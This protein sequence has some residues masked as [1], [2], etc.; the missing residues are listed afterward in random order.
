[1]PDIPTIYRPATQEEFDNFIRFADS[2]GGEWREAYASS[3][4]KVQV[5]DAKSRDSSINIVKLVAVLSNT[6]PLVMYDVLH[7][8]DYRKEWDDN[9]VEGYL[10]EQLDANNDVGYYSAKAP[11]ALVSARDFV[12]E[13]SWRVKED[14]EY[15]IMNHSVVH[16]K[17][18]EQKGFVRANSIMT[19]YLVRRNTTGTGCTLTYITQTDPRGWIPSSL[20]NQLTKTYAP[21]I[22][23]RLDA[24]AAKYRAWKDAHRPDYAPWRGLGSYP[25]KS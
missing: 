6:D 2:T 24:A 22:V 17:L 8:P 18:P 10:I 1:M 9:M 13:R 7:D 23:G 5:W 20:M 21:K 4:G 19:G 11:V 14:L 15:L 12:N 25:A 16:P 3:D